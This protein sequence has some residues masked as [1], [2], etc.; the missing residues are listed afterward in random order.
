[1]ID[2]KALAQQAGAIPIQGQ[3]KE[4]ALAG[5]KEIEAFAAAILQAAAQKCDDIWQEDG[6]ALQC[7]D[8]IRAMK[9][10]GQA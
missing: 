7:R 5:N 3:P 1:M 6:T 10:K 4:L 2:V 9:P 8:A